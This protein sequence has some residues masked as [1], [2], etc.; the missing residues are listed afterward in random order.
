MREQ[1]FRWQDCALLFS[2]NRLDMTL[3]GLVADYDW[4]RTGYCDSLSTSRRG[5]LGDDSMGLDLRA[6]QVR[7]LFAPRRRLHN[8]TIKGFLSSSGS[9]FFVHTFTFASENNL[10]QIPQ[11]L[12]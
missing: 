12:N 4:C 10:F 9:R 11:S 6:W 8:L 3:R 7:C 1:A 5:A 2:T